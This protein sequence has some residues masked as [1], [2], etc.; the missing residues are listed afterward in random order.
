MNRIV[1]VME[2]EADSPSSWRNV[3]RDASRETLVL[4]KARRSKTNFEV[5]DS[6]EEGV[7]TRVRVE[8]QPEAGA[9]GP[10]AATPYFM[11]V[12]GKQLA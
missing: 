5:W 2:D 1:P 12:L 10:A 4:P 8:A 6:D 9:G 11:Q 3:S 7:A